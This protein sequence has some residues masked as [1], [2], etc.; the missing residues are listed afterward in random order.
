MFRGYP[1]QRLEEAIGAAGSISIFSLLFGAVHL[2]NPG[3]SP[4][5]LINTVAIGV[6]LAIA[7]LRTRALWLPWG[8]HFGW[9]VSLGL[10][11]GLP[12]SG[13]RVFNVILHTTVKGPAWFTGGVYGIEASLPVAV[14]ILAGMLLV[15]KWPV[16]RLG[17]PLTY[18]RQE[19]EDVDS[20]TGIQS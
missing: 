18:K 3:A 19:H 14:A 8:I 16:A 1:F 6:V 4:L 15:S 17:E 13:L 9:N 12:V 11:L 20:V 2:T 5:G 7:Y 10:V